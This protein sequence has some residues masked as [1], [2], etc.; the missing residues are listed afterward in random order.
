MEKTYFHEYAAIKET[1][2]AI[3]M[4]R[5]EARKKQP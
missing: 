5:E 1:N 3:A 2:S 4:I